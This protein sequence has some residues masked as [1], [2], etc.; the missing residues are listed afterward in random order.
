MAHAR[1]KSDA[2]AEWSRALRIEDDV[3][4]FCKLPCQIG[5]ILSRLLNV[6]V[7]YT[8]FKHLFRYLGMGCHREEIHSSQRQRNQK[9]GT[10]RSYRAKSHERRRM[11]SKNSFQ[12]KP[13]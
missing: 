5:V 10:R 6:P 7:L 4:D 11:L 3:V 9:P 1:E 8:I 2:L 13:F 12:K